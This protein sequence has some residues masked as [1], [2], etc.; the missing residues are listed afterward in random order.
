MLR[1]RCILMTLVLAGSALAGGCGS[2]TGSA[3]MEATT[4]VA[5][6]CS[7]S[8]RD[9]EPAW[10]RQIADIASGVLAREERL[11]VGCFAG[12][13]TGVEWL[14]AFDSSALPNLTGGASA[15]RRALERWGAALGPFLTRKITVRDVPGT[16]WLSALRACGSLRHA[17][18][19]YLFS[20]L[21]QQ[22]EGIDLTQH[23]SPATLRS[24][25]RQWAPK[26]RELSGALVVEVGGGYGLSGAKPDIQG[27]VLFE[28]LARIVGFRTEMVSTLS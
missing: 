11:L 25:A 21:V 4:P 12:R 26:L 2:G 7:R 18:T 27:V 8:V 17:H 10:I 19:V 1:S 3:A 15:R 9:A 13:R 6:D 23:V 22:G 5:V 16:D 24:Y 28:E 20:D 14:P